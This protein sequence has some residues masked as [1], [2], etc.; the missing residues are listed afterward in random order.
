MGRTLVYTICCLPFRVIIPLLIAVL[1]TSPRVR[2]KSLSRT[3][4]YIPVLM[5]PWSSASPSTG[6]SAR[7]TA[8][9]TS[10]S[11]PSAAPRWNGRSTP[12]CHVRHRFASVWASIGFN[13]IIYVAASTTSH[14]TC[15][16][17][18]ASTVPTAPVFPSHH[19]AH[20]QPHHVPCS[21]A[22]HGKPAQGIRF[23]TGHH[24]GRPRP[25]TTYIIQYI[26]DKG[27][28]QME[29][30]MRPLFHCRDDRV[31]ADR[32]R[33]VQSQQRR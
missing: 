16:R 10:S 2:L 29:Y 20:A 4:I 27:F 17:P 28:N 22:F 32:I 30:A 8:L 5:T 19:G 33:P 9:S 31:C 7:N 21:A 23:G 18:P 25:S 13:M 11:S 26:F 24:A 15:T 1:V 12:A 6:C 14:R 3:M